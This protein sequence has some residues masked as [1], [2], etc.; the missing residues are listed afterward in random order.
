MDPLPDDKIL[1]LSKL[2]AFADDNY[3]MAKAIKFVFHRVENF[4]GKGENAGYQDFLLFLQCFQK[5]FFFP[6]GHQKLSLCG[7]GLNIL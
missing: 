6:Q 1:A 4:E 7:K 3:N 2:E 5:A